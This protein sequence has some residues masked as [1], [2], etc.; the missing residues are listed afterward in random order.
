MKTSYYKDFYKCN[1]I[2]FKKTMRTNSSA[3]SYNLGIIRYLVV[4]RCLMKFKYN[5]YD[6]KRL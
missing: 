2:S 1:L 3:F 6:K 4:N 5:K